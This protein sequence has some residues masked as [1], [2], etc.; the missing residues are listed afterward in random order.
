VGLDTHRKCIDGCRK[1]S[2]KHVFESKSSNNDRF[3]L[4]IGIKMKH[5]MKM[6]QNTM[7]L[8]ILLDIIGGERFSFKNIMVVIMRTVF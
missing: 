3:T 7:F 8:M 2:T 5:F 1:Y 4:F 6:L